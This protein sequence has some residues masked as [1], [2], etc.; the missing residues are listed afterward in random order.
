MV[1]AGQAIPARDL[2]REHPEWLSGSQVRLEIPAARAWIFQMM[3]HFIDEGHVRW[4][5]YDYNHDPL[6]R[7]EPP[8]QARNTR[9]DPNPLP[10]RGVRPFRPPAAKYPDLC[11]ESCASGGRRIDLE[12]IRRA[13]TFWKSDETNNLAV[14]RFHQT[15]G[16]QFLP[17]GLLNTNLP[18]CVSGDPF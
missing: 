14:A 1:R 12:T 8:R 10:A 13:H 7:V 18:G 4:I 15:G 11:I 6:R 16:N 17:G 3:C 5:R 9:P 2:Q